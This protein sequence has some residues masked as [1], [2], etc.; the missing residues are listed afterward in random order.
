VLVIALVAVVSA[1]LITTAL[2]LSLGKDDE[3]ARPA[4]PL[5]VQQVTASLPGVCANSAGVPALDGKTCYEL[6]PGI[7]ITEF[8]KV[9]LSVSQTGGG[10]MILLTLRPAD[11]AAFERLTTRVYQEQPPRNQLALVIDGKVISA[12]SVQQPIRGGQVQIEGGFTRD[13][14]GR[15]VDQLKG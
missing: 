12:P 6:A 9:D 7:T 11:A 2:V 1:A 8:E 15:I 3:T 14:A 13:A 10:W 5:R 4:R